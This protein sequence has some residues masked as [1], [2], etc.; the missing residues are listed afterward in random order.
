MSE[1]ETGTEAF[2]AARARRIAVNVAITNLERAT[3][4]ASS[5]PTWREQVVAELENLAVAFDQHVDE[6]EGEDGLLAELMLTT[7]RLANKINRVQAEHPGLVSMIADTLESVRTS[8]DPA[9]DR[10]MILDTLMAVA[11][12]RQHG[13]DLAYEGYS[14]DIGGG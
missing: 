13:A 4:R 3:A 5:K 12:H 7:P 8:D 11:R 14:V 2:E 6:V 1:N 10:V 9:A